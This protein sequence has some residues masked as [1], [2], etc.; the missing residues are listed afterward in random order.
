[1]KKEIKEVEKA[2]DSNSMTDTRKMIQDLAADMGVSVKGLDKVPF[3]IKGCPAVSFHKNDPGLLRMMGIDPDDIFEGQGFYNTAI[4]P[5][6]KTKG[7]RIEPLRIVSDQ[8]KLIQHDEMVLNVMKSLPTNLGVSAIDIQTTRDGGKCYARFKT[9]KSAEIIPGDIIEFRVGASNSVDATALFKMWHEAYRQWCKNGAMAPDSRFKSYNTRRLHKGGLELGDEIKN[10][11]G[12]LDQAQE[13]IDGW[14]KYAK[15]KLTAPDLEKVF[16]ELEVGP[17]V[18]DELMSTE[19]RGD[20]ATPTLLLEN[21]NLTAWNMFN[22]FTQRI[23]DSKSEELV[24]AEQGL[25]TSEVFER[26]VNA[27]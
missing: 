25:K 7:F 27:A 26:F 12:S 13:V 10:F 8:Y 24:K 15:V 21:K 9:N 5:A 3:I 17:R 2:I 22:A 18:Q 11:V 16:E 19:L 6:T 14:K 23:T 1:M 20:N 4:F